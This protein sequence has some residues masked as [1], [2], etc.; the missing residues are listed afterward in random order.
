MNTEIVGEAKNGAEA[1]EFF[2]KNQPHITLLDINMPVKTGIDTLKEIKSMAPNALVLMMTSVADM[3]TVEECIELGAA[4]YILKD[5]PLTEIK[6][7][8][9]ETWDEYRAQA[10]G[11]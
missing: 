6:I 1:V 4:N 5:T 2:E 3:K 11:A 7:M 10:K 8:I 9:K